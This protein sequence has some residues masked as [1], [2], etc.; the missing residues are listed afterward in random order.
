MT[1]QH[2]HPAIGD[3]VEFLKEMRSFDR[4]CDF[5]NAHYN[6]LLAAYPDEWVAIHEGEV[7]AH[8]TDIHELLAQIDALGVPRGSTLFERL[9]SNPLPMVL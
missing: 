6:D 3:P 2:V 5:Y 9:E 1:T 8:S 7:R 4:S